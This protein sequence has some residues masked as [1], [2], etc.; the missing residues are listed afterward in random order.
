M[1]YRSAPFSMTLNNLELL[2]IFSSWTER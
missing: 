2:N 1:I